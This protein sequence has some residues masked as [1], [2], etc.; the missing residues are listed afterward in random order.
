[1][2]KIPIKQHYATMDSVIVLF[3]LWKQ[4]F[5]C[6]SKGLIKQCILLGLEYTILQFEL[7]LLY[8]KLVFFQFSI[9]QQQN[10]KPHCVWMSDGNGYIMMN[11]DKIRL[12]FSFFRQH[13]VIFWLILIQLFKNCKKMSILRISLMVLF[14]QAL[15]FSISTMQMSITRIKNNTAHCRI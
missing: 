2:K 8:L 14:N 4:I 11:E 7:H 10:F 3:Y 1:M 9:I 12:V 15:F 5:F 13:N 6:C